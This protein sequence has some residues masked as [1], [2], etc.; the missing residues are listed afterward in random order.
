MQDV[1]RLYPPITETTSSRLK[2]DERHELRI[3]VCGNPAGIPVV[4]LHGGPGGGLN[5]SQARTFDPDAYRI[6]LFDQRGAGQSTP[7]ASTADNTTAHLVADIEAIRAHLGI[8]RWLV[9][10]GSWGSCLALAYGEAHPDRCLGFRLHGI[11]LATPG[12]I[13][14]WFQGS[15]ALFPDHWEA[16]AGFVPEDERDRLLDAYHRR[17]NDPDPL[18][19]ETAAIRLR[20]FSASTQTFLPEP[21]HVARLNE[22]KAALSVARLFAHYCTNGAFLEPGQILADLD[23]IRHLPCEI[24]QGR[25]DIVTPVATAWTLH[26]AWPEAR[27]TI[28]EQANHVATAKAPALGNA[29]RDAADRLRDAIA[30][31]T[32][33]TLS[34]PLDAYLTLPTAKSPAVSPD[35]ERLA[36]LS[37]R[38]GFHQI[39][40]RRLKGGTAKRAVWTDE[41][42]GALSFSP[43]GGDLVFT[44][45]RGGDERHQ[46]W[47][48]PT[49][50]GEPV[51]L[52]DAPGVVHLWGAWAPDGQRI[53]Y[54]CNARDARHM[55]IMVMDVG[56]RAARCVYD[57]E[58]YREAVAF[59]DEGE[60]LL[61]RDSRR[62]TT[63][64]GLYRLDLR[65]GSYRAILPHEGKARYPVIKARKGTGGFYLITDQG[66]DFLR[67]GRL[68]PDEGAITWITPEQPYDIDAFAASP[69]GARIA[70]VRNVEGWSRIVLRDLSDGA[71]IE[72]EGLPPGV[73]TS[74]AWS[75][76]GGTLVFALE[77]S[78]TPSDV[79]AY[80]VAAERVT[81][82]TQESDADPARFAFVEPEVERTES[83]DGTTVPFLVYRPDT[84]PPPDGY[85]VLVVVHGGPEAQWTPIFRP[86]LQH[87]LAQGVMVIAPNVRGSTGY[88]RAYMSMDDREQRMDSVAD[89]KAIRLWLRDRAE[90]DDTRVGLFGR[91]YG[92][93]MVLAALTEQPE[94]WRVG[95]EFYGIAN[96][97]TLL[98]TTGPWRE[99]LRAAE[100]GDRFADRAMLERFSPI[101]NADRIRVP[102]LIAHGLDDPRV[103]PGESEMIYS[104]LRGR[105]HPVD[106]LRIPHEG[107]GFA[108]I[109][110]RQVVFGALAR[111]LHRHL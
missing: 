37:D 4:F 85:P 49:E 105:G 26:K 36:Y 34:P 94:L 90:V 2:V 111:F 32:G 87:I 77:G 101:H 24:V 83:F 79:W 25:Y 33:M 60:A 30:A 107:H 89:L 82:L 42:I 95:V 108:R 13:D 78:S 57:G 28:V 16:F 1:D 23:R 66:S 31:S 27:F 96:F 71:E 76:D 73:A 97:L 88:G 10:G 7:H 18:V 50:G 41:P 8:E 70:Y 14:W 55:D 65:T 104:R 68:T 109:E 61:V 51:A 72:L 17:L 47:L 6:V 54:S 103:P 81:N 62:S 38:S 75:P 3:E 63:D 15:R 92:G 58:G 43:K 5:L 64:Q 56:T 86:D 44:S 59:M 100:Y 52:T 11:F 46:L 102:L 29:L 99:T 48:L 74:L 21:A 84:P 91:S 19:C 35:G 67:L 53:A 80:D 45:D 98:Q 69:D 93:F 12:E 40:L 110:N 106:Y 9:A 39:W 22:P 20:T